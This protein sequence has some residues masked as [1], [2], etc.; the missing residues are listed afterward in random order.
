MYTEMKVE[1]YDGVQVWSV[2]HEIM[3]VLLSGSSVNLASAIQ[4]KTSIPCLYLL[5]IQTSTNHM[6]PDHQILYMPTHKTPHP[7]TSSNPYRA[8]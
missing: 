5:I 1:M 6:S 3:I 2:D 8:S 4:V 7:A